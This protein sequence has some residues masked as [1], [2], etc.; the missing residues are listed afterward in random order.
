MTQSSEEDYIYQCLLEKVL[1][2][3][4]KLYS[5][6][7]RRADP[8]SQITIGYSCDQD[9]WFSII[10]DTR[11]D[12]SFDGEWTCFIEDNKVDRGHWMNLDSVSIGELI[13][14]VLIKA[15]DENVFSRLPLN[16]HWTLGVED[17]LGEFG[18]RWPEVEE[19]VD[20]NPFKLEDK[21]I[22]Q[23]NQSN[24]DEKCTILIQHLHNIANQK[25]DYVHIWLLVSDIFD[26]INS[27]EKA[28]TIQ[29]LKLA[30]SLADKPELEEGAK[31]PSSEGLPVTDVVSGCLE[32]LEQSGIV[33]LEVKSLLQGI[34]E[35][36]FL[37]NQSKKFWGLIPY[38]TAYLMS[39]MYDYPE[40]EFDEN[41]T[42]LDSIEVYLK[43]ED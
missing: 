18:W 11:L 19:L 27:L 35:K 14:G 40:P 22:E 7:G 41:T 43:K 1:N 13:S 16:E 29:I 15:K 3:K 28:P 17:Q 39:Q 2:F 10:F 9:G 4:T 8:V 34:L 36:S 42:K 21:K 24:T 12:A 23:F 32:H 25:V 5:G 20:I 33:N 26:Y 37:A 31:D 30:L 38:N 6:P